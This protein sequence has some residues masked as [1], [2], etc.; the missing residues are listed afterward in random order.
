MNVN[1]SGDDSGFHQEIMKYGRMP[2]KNCMCGHTKFR[3]RMTW[4]S[5][6]TFYLVFV[7]EFCSLLK[8]LAWLLNSVCY[9]NEAISDLDITNLINYTIYRRIKIIFT[10]AQRERE[11]ERERV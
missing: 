2:L 11:R 10:E 5:L 4:L 1:S 8:S 9:F 7:I 3:P 6:C